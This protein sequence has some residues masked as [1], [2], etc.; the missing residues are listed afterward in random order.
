MSARALPQLRFRRVEQF[1][2]LA[3]CAA[4]RRGDPIVDVVHGP[5]VE[6]LEHGWFEG[7]WDG[8]FSEFDV[9]TCATTMGSGAVLDSDALRF[10]A[11]SH[12]YESL[13]CVREPHRAWVSNSIACALALADDGPRV[14]YPWYH[15][16]LL[17]LQRRG[18]TGERPL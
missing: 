6:T 15:R 7:V 10:I 12:T 16:D 13:C 17:D 11:P 3:W 5:L 1:P 2:P 4:L 14:E 8:S 18:I 9:A